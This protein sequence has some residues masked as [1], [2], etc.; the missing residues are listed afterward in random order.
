MVSCF[1]CQNPDYKM[2]Y[3]CITTLVNLT[4]SYDKQEIIPEMAELARFAK[5]H[6]PEEHPKV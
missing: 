6:V 5:Q 1:S 4:N 2:T 3:A